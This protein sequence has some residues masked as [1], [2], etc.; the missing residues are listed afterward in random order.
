MN[1]DN[2]PEQNGQEKTKLLLKSLDFFSIF[3]DEELNSFLEFSEMK[4]YKV[5]EYIIREDTE[6]DF[7]YVIIRGTVNIIY[8]GS[9]NVKRTIAT[10]REGD[11]FGE[12]ALILDQPRSAN[13]LAASDCFLF[14][15][16]GKQ[17]DELSLEIREKL[18]RQFSVSLSKRLVRTSCK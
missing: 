8:E 14:K 12:I 4:K 11:C 3:T 7:F 17:I 5:Q 15:I 13:I 1:E 9:N 18:F 2:L 16:D 6:G 10:L